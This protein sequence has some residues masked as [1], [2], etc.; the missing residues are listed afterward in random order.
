M[1][2]RSKYSLLKRIVRSGLLALAAVIV[3][4]VLWMS[5]PRLWSSLSPGK[6]PAGYFFTPAT[7]AAVWLGVEKLMDLGPEIPENIE[8]FRDIEY[9]NINGRSLQLDIYRDKNSPGPAPLIA[10]IHGGSWR[11]GKRSDYLPYLIGLARK[12]YVT[13]T[14]SYRLLRDAPYPACVEDIADAVIWFHSNGDQYGYDTS[15]MALAGGSAGAHL[16]LLAAYGWKPAVL[17]DTIPG[18]KTRGNIKA[19]ADIYGP[20]DLTT[21]YARNHRLVTSFLN[22]S[23]DENPDIFREASPVSYIDGNDPPTLIFH[24]TSD[25]LVPVSQSDRFRELLDSAGVPCVYHRI[26]GWPHTMDIVQR[27]NIYCQEK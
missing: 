4:F 24:G 8:E 9:K 19:V 15:R 13:A 27:V 7:Y 12:G 20:V 6:P 26:P 25:R 17:H 3:V 23:W 5:L 22:S 21:E 14:V 16:A 18:Q 1:A 11:S 2:I 10:F